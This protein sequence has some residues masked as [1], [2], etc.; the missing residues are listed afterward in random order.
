MQHSFYIGAV[1]HSVRFQLW[2]TCHTTTSKGVRYRMNPKT[3]HMYLQTSYIRKLVCVY[4]MWIQGG[5]TPPTLTLLVPNAQRI[6]IVRP[7]SL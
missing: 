1:Q 7:R 6:G 5:H 3:I 4:A 2:A